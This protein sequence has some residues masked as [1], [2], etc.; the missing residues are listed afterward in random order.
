MTSDDESTPHTG[1]PT[2]SSAANGNNSR[3]VDNARVTTRELR[4]NYTPVSILPSPRIDTRD[5]TAP[6]GSYCPTSQHS[7]SVRT[8]PH[9]H[10][11]S[12]RWRRPSEFYQ[13]CIPEPETKDSVVEIYNRWLDK[14]D[15]RSYDAAQVLKSLSE[16]GTKAR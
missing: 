11:V 13:L 7:G 16:G 3:P 1:H 2:P 14:A 8:A 12:L 5:E 15:P 6:S 4:G 10:T 9:K